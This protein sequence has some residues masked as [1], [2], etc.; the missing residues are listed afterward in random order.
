MRGVAS[1]PEDR[2]RALL[3]DEYRLTVARLEPL[4]L[5]LDATA[6]VYRAWSEHGESRFIKVKSEPLYTASCHIPYDLCEQGAAAVVAPLPTRHGALWA[7]RE[8]WSV[9]VY[10]FIEGDSGWSPAMTEAQW[11]ATGAALKSIHGAPL[12]ASGAENIRRETFDPSEYLRWTR[13]FEERLPLA[14]AGNQPEREM[15]TLWLAGQTAIHGGLD[16]LRALGHVLQ[17]ETRPSVIC[18]ADLH[19]SNLIRDAAGRIFVIDWDDVRLAPK[20]RDFL[21]IDEAPVNAAADQRNSPFFR[22]YGQIEIDWIA[23]TYF[24]WERAITDFIECARV[25]FTRDSVGAEA[26]AVEIENFR[27]GLA[28][29]SHAELA[30]V[31]ARRL[32]PALRRA[33]V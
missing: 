2:L 23:L 18:H 29:G 31:A 32:P 13:A 7:Q 25:V 33:L 16:A 4:L 30:R 10:P 6:A 22:G 28:P 11:Q 1:L 5:G 21:F 19:P 3:Q 8:R 9:I 14:A 12:P 15:R 17:R 20:E 24:L 27:A 26:K